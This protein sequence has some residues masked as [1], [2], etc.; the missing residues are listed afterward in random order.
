MVLKPTDD[1]ARWPGLVNR[2]RVYPCAALLML[3]C[4]TGLAQGGKGPSH[5]MIGRDS[6]KWE[7]P[8]AG[9]FRGGPPID[10]TSVWRYARLEG[11][12]LKPGGTLHSHVRVLRRGQGRASLAS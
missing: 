4:S 1:P 5:I 6:V 2:S 11:D 9:M 12:P 10:T 8:P 7:A 3:L